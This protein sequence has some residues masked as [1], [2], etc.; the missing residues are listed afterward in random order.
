MI[1][2]NW[3]RNLCLSF[4]VKNTLVFVSIYG[5]RMM[6]I[7]RHA[8]TKEYMDAN[9]ARLNDEYVCPG[10]GELVCLKKAKSR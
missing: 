2:W 10:C 4:F 3:D 1:Q 9:L 5:G 8:H 6:L 7:A